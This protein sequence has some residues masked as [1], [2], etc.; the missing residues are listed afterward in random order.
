MH[1]SGRPTECSPHIFENPS[2]F[3][4]SRRQDRGPCHHRY[5][6]RIA[7][8][9]GKIHILPGVCF[10][11]RMNKFDCGLMRTLDVNASTGI[12]D[13]DVVWEKRGKESLRFAQGTNR[14]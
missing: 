9:S 5:L 2:Y 12:G 14:R 8:L 1:S 10:E 3:V 11:V 7:Y 4:S 6:V 13:D